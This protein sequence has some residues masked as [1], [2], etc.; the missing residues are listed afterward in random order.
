MTPIVGTE[1]D[2]AMVVQSDVVFRPDDFFSLLESPHDVTAGLYLK[3]PTLAH[4]EPQFDGTTLTP[5]TLG[6][7]QYVEADGAGFGFLLMQKGVVES[8]EPSFWNQAYWSG[9]VHIDT[10]VRVGHRVEI[11]I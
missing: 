1:Y 2:V 4:P 7:D 9:P 5:E 3:E 10:K 8:K 11:V 6:D